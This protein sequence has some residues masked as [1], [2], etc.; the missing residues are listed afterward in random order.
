MRAYALVGFDPDHDYRYLEINRSL[1]RLHP[2]IVKNVI[3]GIHAAGGTAVQMLESDA[4]LINEEITA[5]IVIAR[6]K[7]TQGGRRRWKI[8]L[9]ESLKLDLAICVRMDE[10]NSSP[11]DFYILP[12]MTLAESVMRLA[13]HNGLSLDA[14]RFDSLDGL[15]I[16]AKRVPFRRAA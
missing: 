3:D 16:L 10:D 13:D 1:R 12:R 8:R 7:L 15:F 9:E 4:L 5:S 6:C 11:H 14:F 2:A